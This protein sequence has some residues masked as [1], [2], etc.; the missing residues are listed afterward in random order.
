M[1]DVV[2]GRDAERPAYVQTVLTETDW[3]AAARAHE[4]R[5][6][7]ILTQHLARRS[8]GRKHPVI[9]FLFEYYDFRPAPLRRWS[10]GFGVALQGAADA[11]LDRR[12][13]VRTAVGVVLEPA[14]F[15]EKQVQATRWMHDLVAATDL[16]APFFGC[17]GMHEWAMVYRADGV[18]HMQVPLR[19]PADEIAAIVEAQPIACSHFDAFRFFTPPARPL[20]RLQPTREAMA[21]FEQP[22]CLHANM[23]VYRWA[24]KRYPWVPSDLI[25]D[26]F[27]LACRIREVDM[28]A[29]PYDLRALGYE[30]IPVETPE[31]RRRYRAYQRRFMEEAAPLR[32][33]L[34]AAY[35]HLLAYV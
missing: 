21:D 24:F 11:F 34:L 22:A 10:P 32:R 6:A 33:R 28:R 26:A 17:Y 18:R 2:N 14:L 4:G 29:S 25:A 31:G 5:L 20:N 15:P 35:D 1:D 23:D 16:R 3:R 9:D 30:P 8:A 12:G 19:Y 13:F 27:L 7:P